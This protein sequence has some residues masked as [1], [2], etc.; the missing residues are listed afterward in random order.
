[1]VLR[2][3]SASYQTGGAGDGEGDGVTEGVVG[4]AAG[5][6][7]GGGRWLGAVWVRGLIRVL[8]RV[9][10]L[11]HVRVGVERAGT[12]DRSAA[13]TVRLGR[14]RDRLGE[15][16]RDHR[17]NAAQRDDRERPKPPRAVTFESVASVPGHLAGLAACWPFLVAVGQ[18]SASSCHRVVRRF[19]AFI[20]DLK[21]VAP[22]RTSG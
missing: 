4:G 20:G 9:R 18:W 12:G 19:Y 16:H 2:E 13:T 14:Q 7:A 10:W 15:Q 8:A 1:M 5:G 3:D 17:H 6:A 22:G 21:I 11:R